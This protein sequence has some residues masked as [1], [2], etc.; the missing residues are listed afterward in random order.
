MSRVRFRSGSVHL[1]LQG[2]EDFV[3]RQLLLLRDYLGA[4]DVDALEAVAPEPP[5]PAEAETE[6]ASAA[7]APPAEEDALTA[8]FRAHEPRG[9][10]RQAEAALLF[11]YYLQKEE[12]MRAL[13][14]RD[15][16]R[17]CNRTGVDTRNFNRTLGALTR[18]GL[19][20]PL[21]HGRGY[22]LSDQGRAAV[23][24]RI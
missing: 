1:E 8:F 10:Q 5:A 14:L 22:R 3:T 21:R 16:I 12:G 15:L 2:S 23:E 13:E 20:E 4:V 19:L 6:F 17:C 24:N 11:A 18:R 9:K 7:A